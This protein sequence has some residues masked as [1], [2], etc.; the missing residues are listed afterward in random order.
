M[1]GAEWEKFAGFFAD[2]GLISTR[3]TADEMLTND[4]LPG[5]IPD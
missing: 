3:P 4:L 1:D 5:Q 2:N